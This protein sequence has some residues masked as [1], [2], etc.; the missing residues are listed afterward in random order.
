[1]CRQFFLHE[2]LGYRGIVVT[3]PISVEVHTETHPWATHS[4]KDD[5]AGASS[6]SEGSGA[7]MNILDA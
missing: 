7:R 3:E 2:T 6:D 5:A 1:M 4:P